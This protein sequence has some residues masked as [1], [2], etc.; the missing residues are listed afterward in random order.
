MLLVMVF[1][2]SSFLDN[3][4]AALIGGT[5]ARA[6]FRGKVHIGY[7]AAIV[8]A[9]NAGG[10]GQR[11]R[12]HDDD[13]DVD[14][15]RLA[16]RGARGVRRGRRRARV[17]GI[18]AAMQQHALLADRSSD[19]HA[20]LRIDWVRVAIVAFILRARDRRERRRQP[21]ASTRSRTAFPFIGVG[22]LGRDPRLARRCAARLG[23]AA[24][25]PSRARMFL[26][27]L[28]LSAS[29]M[30]VRE[31]AR[32][33][34]ADR[35]RPGLRLGGVRQHSADRARVEAGRLRLGLP[36][37]RGRLRRLDDLVRLV[38][39][40][41][42]VEQFPE[43]DPSW[44][45]SGAAGTWRSRMSSA[46]S[47]CSPLSDGIPTCVDRSP[48]CTSDIS[49]SRARRIRRLRERAGHR[50]VPGREFQRSALLVE[51]IG[52]R[53]RARRLQRPRVVRH[54]SWRIVAALLGRLLPRP[55]RD[56]ARGQLSVVGRDGPR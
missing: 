6:V 7:L 13:D 11:R 31:A 27:S 30:P 18:P 55:M 20:R 38:G 12:R 53:S 40:R 35:A 23:G 56:A 28:V 2:L 15:R 49:A 46:F 22:G 17:F 36:R 26:L 10:V 43:Q 48:S 33:V 24:R 32:R 39:R 4:A 9:S 3:I 19:A 52:K 25:R 21:R 42:A 5:M 44:R 8:A 54:D 41:R 51:Q 47:S 45:G 1:V 14:R 50:A 34:V 37:V 16:A 29:M